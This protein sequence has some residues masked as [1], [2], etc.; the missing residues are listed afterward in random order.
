M[1]AQPRER[2]NERK[3][4]QKTTI[5]ISNSIK[6]SYYRFIYATSVCIERSKYEY[7]N[8]MVKLKKG[9]PSYFVHKFGKNQPSGIISNQNIIVITRAQS[10]VIIVEQH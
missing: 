1:E 5:F 10:V 6:S 9:S 2:E 3:K 4:E 8:I 7:S